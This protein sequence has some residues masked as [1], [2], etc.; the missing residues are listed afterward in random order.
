[1]GHATADKIAHGVLD[2]HAAD[3]MHR[4]YG[5]YWC[6]IVKMSSAPLSRMEQ[7]RLSTSQLGMWLGQS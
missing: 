7:C 5:R 3:A 6:V 4:A 1:M 2:W